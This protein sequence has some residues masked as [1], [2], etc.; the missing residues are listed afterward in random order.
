MDLYPALPDDVHLTS[1]K[2]IFTVVISVVVHS[3]V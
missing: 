3:V 2:Y 1:H